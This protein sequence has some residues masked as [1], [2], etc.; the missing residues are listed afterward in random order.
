MK[1]IRATEN[2]AADMLLLNSFVHEMHVD[3][4][5][6]IFKPAVNNCETIKF[7]E[8]LLENENNYILIAYKDNKALG[9]IWAELQKRPENP[10][11]H[12]Y[13]QFYIYHVSVHKDFKGQGIGK[14]L[15]E[16]IETVAKKQGITNIALDVWEFNKESQEIFKKLGFA[17][18]NINMWKKI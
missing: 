2:E 12:E 7:F 16:E 1:I 6:E 11:L 5:P 14:A 8:E 17:A 3:T 9:Y 4:Y 18:Y 13:N 10:L 15:F